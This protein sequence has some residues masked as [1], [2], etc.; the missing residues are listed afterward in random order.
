M[1]RLVVY[2]VVPGISHRTKLVE[3]FARGDKEDDIVVA[4]TI[5]PA[6]TIFEGGR[7]QGIGRRGSVVQAAAGKRSGL[8]DENRRG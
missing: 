6:R 3:V 5:G 8:I 2:K 1:V 4:I 7:P